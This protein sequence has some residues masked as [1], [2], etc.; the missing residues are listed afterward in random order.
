M[1]VGRASEWEAGVEITGL[2][3]DIIDYLQ[4]CYEKLEA[5]QEQ[6]ILSDP[7]YVPHDGPLSDAKVDALIAAID[8]KFHHE[9][10]NFPTYHERRSGANAEPEFAR[11]GPTA[12]RAM[13][14]G[15]TRIL[16]EWDSR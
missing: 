11:L 8:G 15:L 3:L 6:L 14:E 9:I 12:R 7:F 10:T 4:D 2:S 1:A 13:A 5:G 16:D